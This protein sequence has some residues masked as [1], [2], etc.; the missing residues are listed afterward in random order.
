M[1]T[2]VGVV[3]LAVDASQRQHALTEPGLDLEDFF[4]NA[5]I[6]LCWL[7]PDGTVLRANRTELDLVGYTR[8]EY[9]G[10]DV[11]QCHVDPQIMEDVLRRLRAG[12]TI[13]NVEARLRHRDGSI[14]HVLFSASAR[15]EGGRFVHARCV[16]RDVTDLKRAPHAV[17]YFTDMVESADEASVA[18]ERSSVV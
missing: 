12:E 4:E 1:G 18:D 2:I 5:S 14:R 8:D 15:M 10:R 13:R 9:V 3:G 17:A 7:G 6:G 16:T 11:R